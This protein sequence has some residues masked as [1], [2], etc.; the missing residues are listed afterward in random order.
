MNQEV[1]ASW[2]MSTDDLEAVCL[3]GGDTVRKV[4][5]LE[6]NLYALD[7]LYLHG[8]DYSREHGLR[9]LCLALVD[10]VDSPS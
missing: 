10:E 2:Q 7:F 6:I 9:G 5:H 1:H 8:Y 3:G 4:D